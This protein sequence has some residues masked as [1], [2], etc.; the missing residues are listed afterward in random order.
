[1]ACWM[2][3]KPS[4]SWMLSFLMVEYISSAQKRASHMIKS[5]PSD[6]YALLPNLA[7]PRQRQTTSQRTKTSNFVFSPYCRTS[8]QYLDKSWEAS[9]T[10]QTKQRMEPLPL[11]SSSWVTAWCGCF[12]QT[13]TTILTEFNPKPQRQSWKKFRVHFVKWG[14]TALESTFLA[15]KFLW[16]YASCETSHGIELKVRF[17]VPNVLAKVSTWSCRLRI[18]GANCPQ[19]EKTR[20]LCFINANKTHFCTADIH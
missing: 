16:R 17:L 10:S 14:P 19:V 15:V 3:I 8:A 5:G 1:M 11:W 4:C 13:S 2:S 12:L 6:M 9:W 18:S 7:S 20:V